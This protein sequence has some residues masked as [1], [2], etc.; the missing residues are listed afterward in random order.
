M[1]KLEFLFR[2]TIDLEQSYQ[3]PKLCEEKSG[4]PY[5]HCA[6]IVRGCKQIFDFM[7]NNFVHYSHNC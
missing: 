1:K 5:G 3:P 7:R 2:K 6:H 4:D